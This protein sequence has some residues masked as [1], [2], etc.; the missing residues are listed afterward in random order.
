MP[1]GVKDIIDVA[2]LPTECGSEARRGHVARSDAWIVARLREAGAVPIGK[3]VT[4]E[5]AYFRPGPTRNPHDLERTPGGS[6]SGSA[7]AVAAGMVPFAL[8]TQTAGSVTRPAAFCG[9]AG[10]VAPTGTIAMDGIVGMCPSLDTAGL[11]ATTVADVQRVNAVLTGEPVSAVW[12]RPPRLAAWDGTLIGDVSPDMRSGFDR[13]CALAAGAGAVLTPLGT[14][15]AV[16]ELADAHLT[17]MAY[18]AARSAT[19][20]PLEPDQLGVELRDLRDA[21]LAVSDAEYRSALACASDA[22]VRIRTAFEHADAIVAPAALG[23]APAGLS[24]TGSPLLSRPWQLLGLPA[25]AIP[26]LVDGN[27]LP[28]GIQLLGSGA[29]V[30]RLLA[31]GRWMQEVLA[32]A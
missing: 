18:E 24:A 21:G 2:G 32:P 30:S 15:I 8:G 9:V 6:S 13:G 3:T 7:A 28:L 26:G 27:G 12:P 19:L 11:L 14:S 23:A 22:R 17:V 4:T 31:L 29:R 1:F 20:R 5:F 10:Y 25:I 16:A